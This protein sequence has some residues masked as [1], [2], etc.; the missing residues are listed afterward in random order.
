MSFKL[1]GVWPLVTTAPGTS[2][3]ALVQCAPLC[4]SFLSSEMGL[5]K[6]QPQGSW[7]G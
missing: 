6:N 2:G 3:D 1:P 7:R 4:L 5:W